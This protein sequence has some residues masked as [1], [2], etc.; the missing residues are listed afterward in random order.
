M[1]K[2]K[3]EDG[4]EEAGRKRGRTGA[5]A[6]GPGALST[7]GLTH[8]EPSRRRL[9]MQT[10]PVCGGAGLWGFQGLLYDAGSCLQTVRAGP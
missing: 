7:P 2:E 6:E 4:E 3:G 10:P 9:D 8:R 1:E 5:R